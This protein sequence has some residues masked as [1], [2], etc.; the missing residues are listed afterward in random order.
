[1]NGADFE[2]FTGIYL[3]NVSFSNDI[4]LL[5]VLLLLVVFA[6]IFRHNIPLFSK[7]L[8]NISSGVQRQSIFETAESDSFLFTS[9]M[10][11]QTL[12]LCSIF[13]FSITIQYKNINNPDATTTFTA[14][15]VLIVTLFI[16]FL[17]KRALYALF[18]NIFTDKAA[19]KM[20]FTNYQ[21]IF[22][23]W[24]IF[25]YFPVLWIL[26]VGNYFFIAVIFMIIS[27][28]LFRIILIYRFFYIFFN[29]NTELLFFSLYLCAQE[30][31]PL[32]FLYEGLIY[33][34]NNI[35]NNNIWQ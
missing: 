4:M 22:C 15:G 12:L 21:A 10:T 8:N 18:G 2:G 31:V 6:F 32:V 28:L 1:M 26:L 25:L 11:F 23:V 5:I 7:M 9:F 19:N 14:I 34:Y 16:F 30:I 24:G 13:I 35:E 27:Y 17:F 29:R 20:L 33:I 3:D